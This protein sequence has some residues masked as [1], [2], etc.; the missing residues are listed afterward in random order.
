MGRVDQNSL[1]CLAEVIRDLQVEI[2]L[3]AGD[4]GR[5]HQ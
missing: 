4:R 3:T 5:S 1:E 2:E